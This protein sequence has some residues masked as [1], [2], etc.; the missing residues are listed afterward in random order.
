MVILDRLPR[1]A[2]TSEREP[3]HPHLKLEVSVCPPLS[4]ESCLLLPEKM[5]L[6]DGSSS[7]CRIAAYTHG[8]MTLPRVPEKEVA[9]ELGTPSSLT[10]SA[11]PIPPKYANISG[12]F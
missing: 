9:L 6:L 2:P 4:S 5:N 11:S 10:S 8:V 3:A 1:P 12:T 7:S